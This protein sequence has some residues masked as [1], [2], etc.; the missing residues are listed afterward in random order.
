M[1]VKHLI[2][3]GVFGIFAATALV[4]AQGQKGTEA[5]AAPGADAPEF[6]LPASNGKSISLDSYEGKYVVLEWTNHDCPYVV[7]HYGGGSMQKTQKWATDKGV[8]WLQIIS[9]APGKQGYLTADQANAMIKEKG[10]NSTALLL[11]PDGK[12][13]KMYSARTTPHMF[14][15]DPKGKIIYAGG[16]DDKATANAADIATSTNY[17][18]QALEEALAGKSVSVATSRPYGCSVKY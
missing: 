9:S 7:K 8:V 6:T 13:G 5:S 12:V 14:V 16:I 2:S 1:K 10:F 4:V 3:I 17:I 11:D 18:K 15:I